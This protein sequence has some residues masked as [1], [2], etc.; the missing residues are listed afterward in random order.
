MKRTYSYELALS[1]LDEFDEDMSGL[2]ENTCLYEEPIKHSKYQ[3]SNETS[4]NVVIENET[5]CG[6]DEDTLAVV[7]SLMKLS[8]RDFFDE[9]NDM[10]RVRDIIHSIAISPNSL[11]ILSNPD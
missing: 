6:I 5:S 1:L 10:E 3:D 9:T 8:V 2:F 4:P 7:T 11:P